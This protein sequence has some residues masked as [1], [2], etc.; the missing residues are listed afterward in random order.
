MCGEGLTPEVGPGLVDAHPGGQ[1]A[2]VGLRGAEE[3]VAGQC[4]VQH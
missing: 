3:D 4:L 1:S 2:V